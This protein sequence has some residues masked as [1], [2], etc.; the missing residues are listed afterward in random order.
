MDIGIMGYLCP[1]QSIL[2]LTGLT[3]RFIAKSEGDFLH[4]S[5]DPMYV[6]GRRPEFI[7]LTLTAPG[8]SYHVP[9][10]GTSFR[11]WTPMETNLADHPEF[12][13][14]YVRKRPAPKAGNWL[15]ALACQLGA[16]RVFEHA[17]P[18]VYYLLAV[19]RRLSS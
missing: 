10:P 18:G 3:D 2:D 17:H 14:T 12:A 16:E 15:D 5:Y 13:G 7:V 11:A 9:P 1:D 4:K 8:S 6:L 19:Y